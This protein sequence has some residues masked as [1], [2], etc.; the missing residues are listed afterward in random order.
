MEYRIEKD[1]I[2]EVKVVAEA[3]STSGL[4]NIAERDKAGAS[5]KIDLMDMQDAGIT[6]AADALQGKISGLDIISSSG[7]PGSGSQLVHEPPLKE[8]DMQR[9]K[10]D[11]T[12]MRE[13]L[14]RELL[15]LEEGIRKII[16]QP[17]FIVG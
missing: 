9:R 2:G 11:I 1:T 15:P 12:K 14:G 5:V 8:G 17:E 7:D 13:L 10:P 16:A 3:R 6:S 4:T